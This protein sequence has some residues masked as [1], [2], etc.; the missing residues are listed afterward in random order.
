[1]ARADEIRARIRNRHASKTREQVGTAG[2]PRE[3]AAQNAPKA[4]TTH[5]H[6][7][8]QV[9]VELPVPEPCAQCDP[10]CREAW[11]PE[12][13]NKNNDVPTVPAV[14]ARSDRVGAI[15]AHDRLSQTLRARSDFRALLF[16]LC[17]WMI[18]RKAIAEI[19]GEEP[20]TEAEVIA[21]LDCIERLHDC[22]RAIGW[23]SEQ[24]EAFKDDVVA[25]LER[26]LPA[27]R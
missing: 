24:W 25:F 4:P 20:P 17:E 16:D 9:S 1:M 7:W 19:D 22:C 15:S 10:H 18:E 8:E 3:T 5:G 6:D 27:F 23:S 26:W 21:I 2:T 13:L 14:P 12:I 11:E